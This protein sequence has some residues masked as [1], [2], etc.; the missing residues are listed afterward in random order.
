M[1]NDNFARGLVPVNWP[2]ISAHYYRVSTSVNIFLGEVVDLASTGYV[3]N[4]IDVTTAGVVQ[5]IGVAVGFAGPNKA[6]LAGN[7]SFLR[8]ADLTTLASGLP[9]GDRFVLVA[10][11]PNQ[12]FIVQGDTGGTLAGLANAGETAALIYR[13]GGSGNTTSGWANLELDAS[14]NTTGSAQLLQ[15]VQLNDNV[16]VDGTNNAGVANYAKWVVKFLTHRLAGG[17][18]VSPGV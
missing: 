17:A 1:A 3:G 16:N 11:D 18:N 12:R 10:D 6:G 7:D 14:T 13:G 9:T 4:T 15:L 5:A 2:F 8:A